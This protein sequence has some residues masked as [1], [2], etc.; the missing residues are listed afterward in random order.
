M[1]MF[2]ERAINELLAR[3]PSLNE[4]LE[5]LIGR[6]L[7]FRLSEPSITVRMTFHASGVH[8]SHEAGDLNGC[9]AV[10]EATM[11]GL[12]SLAL[13]RGQ[14]S[15]DVQLRGDIGTIQEVRQLFSGLN[16]DP[17]GRLGAGQEG[18]E[19]LLK[20]FAELATEER[21]W[22]PTQAEAAE[23]IAGVDLLREATDRLEAR[24]QRLEPLR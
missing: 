13:S 24:L 2:T 19:T 9:D 22:L 17:D 8:L 1:A 16:L 7:G 20:N 14:R 6:T 5:P 21:G 15:R 23:F 11:A 18:V 3:D 4:R 10:I 12:A